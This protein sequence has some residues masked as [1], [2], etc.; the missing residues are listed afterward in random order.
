[1]PTTSKSK[2]PPIVTKTPNEIPE[3]ADFLAAF[4]R[5]EAFRTE[6]ADLMKQLEELAVDYNQKLEAAALKCRNADVSCGPFDLYQ[7]SVKYSAQQ[8]YDLIGEERFLLVG[9]TKNTK[10]VYDI[11]KPRL[12]MAIDQGK[13]PS[14]VVEAVRTVS[15]SYHAPKKIELP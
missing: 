15:P 5:L 9:G 14:D 6:H 7:H 11:D 3:V 2:K 13:I 1:M 8:L 4:G 10:T 12:E